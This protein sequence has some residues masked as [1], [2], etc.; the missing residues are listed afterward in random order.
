MF[1]QLKSAVFWY[2][3][4]KFRR[5]AI[6]IILLLIIAFFANAIYEDVV[7][8]LTLKN[9]LSYLELVLALKW[10]IIIFNIV[11]SIYLLFT[12][13]KKERK[14]EI[15][16]KELISKKSKKTEEVSKN[17]QFSQR[18]EKFLKKKKLRTQADILL[19]K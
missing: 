4:F 11:F 17:K 5:R 16:E 6:L 18:E 7:Q 3:L 8:Y 2:Y 15:K 14:D 12:M 19:E 9:K 13:F 1:R 10:V